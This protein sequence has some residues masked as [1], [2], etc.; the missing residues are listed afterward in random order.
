MHIHYTSMA[1]STQ[2][3]TRVYICCFQQPMRN[4]VLFVIAMVTFNRSLKII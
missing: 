3:T 1:Y 2:L 4:V